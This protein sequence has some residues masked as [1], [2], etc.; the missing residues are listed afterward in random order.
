MPT[1]IK[2]NKKHIVID[3]KNLTQGSP[4]LYDIEYLADNIVGHLAEE[5]VEVNRDDLIAVIKK[6]REVYNQYI[7]SES[8][9]PPEGIAFG[10]YMIKQFKSNNNSKEFKYGGNSKEGVKVTRE[11]GKGKIFEIVSYVDFNEE[12][13]S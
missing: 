13:I 7:G 12:I 6:Q 5:N 2:Y 1:N 3:Y 8:S 10:K 11:F 9:L 4:G